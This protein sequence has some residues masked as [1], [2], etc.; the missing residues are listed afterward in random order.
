LAWCVWPDWNGKKSKL[1]LVEKDMA[2]TAIACSLNSLTDWGLYTVDMGP[3]RRC[4]FWIPRWTLW[5]V[6]FSFYFLLLFLSQ[7]NPALLQSHVAGTGIQGINPDP[8]CIYLI[9]RHVTTN[10]ERTKPPHLHLQPSRYLFLARLA[11]PSLV[12]I[13]IKSW[14]VA[15]IRQ[16]MEVEGD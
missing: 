9:T 16:A 3:S 11:I 15:F 6:Q 12:A 4:L 13:D 5:L 8:A 14:F 10:K 1:N 7:L 2:A